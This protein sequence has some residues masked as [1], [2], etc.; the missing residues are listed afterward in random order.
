MRVWRLRDAPPHA[1]PWER[2]TPTHETNHGFRG[3]AC[4]SDTQACLEEGRGRPT[5]SGC[6]AGWEQLTLSFRLR[7]G[8]IRRANRSKDLPA[9]TTPQRAAPKANQLHN[10]PTCKSYSRDAG[11]LF[12]TLSWSGRRNWRMTWSVATS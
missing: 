9:P 3:S 4:A 2:R 12:R 11:A 1:K 8:L 5:R 10:H 7:A 6:L